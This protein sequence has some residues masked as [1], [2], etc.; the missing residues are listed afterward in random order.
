MAEGVY[1]KWAD[2]YGRTRA[3]YETLATLL[4]NLLE[5]LVRDAEIDIVQIEKR[6]KSVDSFVGKL[7]RKGDQYTDPLAEVT[8]LAGV[9][10]ITYY[11][12]DVDEVGELIKEEFE[13]DDERS[14]D[15]RAQL[16]PDRFGYV[17]THFIVRLSE[18][19]RQLREW[20][21]LADLKAEIQVRTATQHAWAAVEHK[22][23]YKNREETAPGA[24]QRRMS[25]LSALFELADEQFAEAKA[26]QLAE[27]STQ[28]DRVGRGDLD[29]HVNT[30]SLKAYL[31]ASEKVSAALGVAEAVGWRVRSEPDPG[32]PDRQ[33]RD[34]QDLVRSLQMLDVGRITAFDELI[35]RAGEV[36]GPLGVVAGRE[37]SDQVGGG[38]VDG[39]AFP[40]D[41]LNVIV[42]LLAKAPPDVITQIYGGVTADAIS[43]AI[44]HGGA[45]S[46]SDP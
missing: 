9:R 17:S 31:E 6:A 45:G 35:G 19:R 13:V 32:D 10:V 28:K 12:E 7:T 23:H 38:H 43:E 34:L 21:E 22:L 26:V 11:L 1:Q 42:F 27:Q 3:Q 5:R 29:S 14:V 46:D 16:D 30:T 36:E 8:D 40:E 4:A 37:A 33:E 24:I 39:R 44:E 41:I 18:T 2:E 25:R 20:S 15:K